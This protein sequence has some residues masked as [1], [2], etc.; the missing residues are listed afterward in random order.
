MSIQISELKMAEELQSMFNTPWMPVSAEAIK[1]L[2]DR[3][4]EVG[5]LA[6][7]ISPNPMSTADTYD[8]RYWV[9]ESYDVPLDLQEKKEETFD[10]LTGEFQENEEVDLEGVPL[11]IGSVIKA[12]IYE[13]DCFD[14]EQ[15]PEDFEAWSTVEATWDGKRFI[16]IEVDGC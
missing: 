7:L 5:Y 15:D 13:A 9:D 11:R 6:F 14:F 1:D 12:K 3:C 10:E 16:N 4:V 8:I 2:R